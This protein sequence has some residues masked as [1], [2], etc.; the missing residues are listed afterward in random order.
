MPRIA[1]HEVQRLKVEVSL[2]RLV[3]SSGVTLAKRGDDMVGCCP[4]HADD[5][6][7]LVVS[8]AKNLFNCFGCGAGGGVI[9]WVMKRE[10]VSFRHAVEVL[11][12]DGAGVDAVTPL[13]A[14]AIKPTPT[15]KLAAP[16]TL[17]VDDQHLLAQVVGYYHETLKQSPEALAYLQSRGLSHPEL[18][19]RFRLGYAN[20]TLGLRLPEKNRKAGAEVRGR[21]ERVGIYRSS[22]HEHFAGSLVV[23]VMG[24]VDQGAPV[25]ELYGRKIRNDLRAGTPLHLYLPGPHKGVWNEE[26]L[27]ASGGEIILTESLI[28]AMTFWVAGYRNV[29]AS[30]GVQGFAA[31][32]LDS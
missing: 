8:V 29:T 4:F 26:G 18:I 2:V 23:P 14:S 25:T 28:D 22:G 21:L 20:R 11:R 19:T 5:S 16:V 13:A 31:D 17:D 12:A 7:S 32:H 15:R 1:D 30:Y 3:E 27:A 6:P 24:P 10:G 9:D